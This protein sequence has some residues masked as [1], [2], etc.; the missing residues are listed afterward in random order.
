MKAAVI[1]KQ[2]GAENIVWRDWPNPVPAADQV[3]VRVR[4]CGLNHLDI[5]VRRGMPGMPVPMPFI[6]GGDIAGE[7]A[8]IGSGVK[9]FAI[10]NRVVLNPSTPGGMM[11][12]QIQGGMAE[13]AVAPASHVIKLP[14]SVSF[15]EA[16]CLPVAYGTAEH[17]LNVRGKVKAGELVLV[18]GASGGVGNA[19]VQIAKHVG[20]T[21]I[22]ATGG[23]DKAER[24]RELG[25]DHVID[26]RAEDFSAAA[27]RIS[28][29]RGVDLVVNFTGGNTW[30]PSL[31]TLR[32]DG[33]LVT[34]GAT[35]GYE[36]VTDIRYVW[37][38]ELN[39]IGCDGWS[40]EGIRKMVDGV[41]EGWLTP[42]ISQV[43]PMSEAARAERLMEERRIFGK[44]ILEP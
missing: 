43:L 7:V 26:Y 31:R 11:G 18:L 22:A 8:A 34:C 12:E 23:A 32:K 21:V 29:K 2:G 28:G 14:D 5:F 40:T 38:R 36:A 30:A 42:V 41:A 25:A 39:I 9:G 15:L 27:W 16:A 3:L 10:G 4:A 20:A 35:A 37:I 6:S 1:E 24:L 17:M 44:V 13:Y 33:R 19:C